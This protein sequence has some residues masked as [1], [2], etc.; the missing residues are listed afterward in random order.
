[1]VDTQYSVRV[2]RGGSLLLRQGALFA[3]CRP[4]L[5][6]HR[7]QGRSHSQYMPGHMTSVDNGA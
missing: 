7:R 4:T 6:R 1:M 3:G 5:T 2:L